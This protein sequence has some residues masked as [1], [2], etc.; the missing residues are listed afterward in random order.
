[1]RTIL[2]TVERIAVSD[3]GV[4][5]VGERGTGKKWFAHVIHKVSGRSG[6][7]FVHIDCSAIPSDAI[8][9]V[10]LGWEDLTLGGIEIHE[11][12]LEKASGGTIF[13]NNICDMPV[14]VLMKIARILENQQFRRVGGF[15]EIGVNIRVLAVL[16]KDILQEDEGNLLARDVCSRFC[17]ITIN[18]P[19]LRERRADIPFLIDQFIQEQCPEKSRR[20]GG[21]TADALN[22][23]RSYYWPGNS[24][25]LR[26]V[27]KHAIERCSG[28]FIQGSHLP[29]YL[30]GQA[31]ASNNYLAEE[32]IVY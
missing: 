13:F 9:K 6:R 25:E 18:L 5:I 11:G 8:E 16:S 21:I 28:Q 7:P 32:S 17:P 4:L 14:P 2:E 12:A 23:C 26:M 30:Q 10:L 20:P 1:M 24:W 31:K 29:E 3:L 22:I 27:V 15:E 19:P